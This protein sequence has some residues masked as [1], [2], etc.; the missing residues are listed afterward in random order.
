MLPTWCSTVFR[1][2]NKRSAI[3]GF[4]KPWPMSSSTSASRLVSWPTVPLTALR[5][6]LER[7]PESDRARQ[8]L[9]TVLD[10]QG[11]GAEAAHV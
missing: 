4:D 5:A 2:M 3:S 10:L 6:E 8:M 11:N 7:H 9:A 1:L